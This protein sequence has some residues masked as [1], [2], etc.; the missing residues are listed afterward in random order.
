MLSSTNTS[1]NPFL[2]SFFYHSPS[3][4]G[5]YSDDIFHNH[6]DLLMADHLSRP[7]SPV[8]ETAV[9]VVVSDSNNAPIENKGPAKKDRHSK[10][11]TAQGLRDR[12]VRLSIGIARKFF[13]LQDMLGFDKASKTLEWLLAKS[14]AAIVE[15]AQTKHSCSAAAKSLSSASVCQITSVSSRP[16]MSSKRKSSLIGLSK[17]KKMKKQPYHGA[18]HLVAKEVRAKARARARERTREKMCNRKLS[19]PK[20]F[21]VVVSDANEP[22]SHSIVDQAEKNDCFEESVKVGRKL[23]PS[24]IFGFQQNLVISKD[25]TPNNNNYLPNLHQNWG[26]SSAFTHSTFCA[27]TNMNLSSELHTYGKAWEAYNNQ[28][29]H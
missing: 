28:S 10:I 2:P 14:T 27:M 25:A 9:N 3:F 17:K 1:V 20:K 15:V 29:L 4:V 26:I 19:E 21:P 23:T 16:Q 11:C 5:H 22:S 24:S 12:R 6:Q 18:S 8:A 13:D 7:N